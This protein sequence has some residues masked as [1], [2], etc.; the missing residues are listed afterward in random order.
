[1]DQSNILLFEACQ[2]VKKDK[3]EREKMMTGQTE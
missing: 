1:M 3:K 2:A